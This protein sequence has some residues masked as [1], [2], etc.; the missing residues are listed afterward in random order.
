MRSASSRGL[1]D[2]LAVDF[3]TRDAVAGQAALAHAEYVAFAAQLQ[4]PPRQCENPS[5]VFAD[6]FQPG[7]R[8]LTERLRVEQQGRSRPP[9]RVRYG[10]ANWCS[11]ARPKAFGILDHHDGRRRHVDADLD[12]GGCDQEPDPR[13]R[14]NWPITRSF[15]VPFIWPWTRPTR[16]PK[17]F[18]QTLEALGCIGQVLGALS[19]G[20]LDQR[21]DPVDQFCRLRSARPMLSVTSPRRLID[22]V[23]GFDRLATGRLSRAIR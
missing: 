7:L 16:S 17:R 14:R 8:H 13:G 9:S 19:L 23:R 3:R 20:F 5:V 18:L 4:N 2:E 21:A 12:H 11:C 15:S 1:R 6:H 22:M 10:R